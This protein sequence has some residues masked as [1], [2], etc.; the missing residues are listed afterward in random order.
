MDARSTP[1]PPTTPSTPLTACSLFSLQSSLVVLADAQTAALRYSEGGSLSDSGISDTGS[2]QEASER[3]RR[4][5][6]LRRLARQLEAVLRPG[7]SALD[8]MRERILQAEAEL[9]GLQRACRD[10]IVRTAVCA[11]RTGPAAAAAATETC[12]EAPGGPRARTSG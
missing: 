9:R 8:G 10:L 7:S 5:A 3:E 6:G 4:L 11:S 2:D 1:Y 12:K